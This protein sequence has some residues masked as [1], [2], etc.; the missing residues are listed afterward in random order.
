M[1]SAFDSSYTRLP[2]DHARVFRRLGLHPGPEF[3]I[4]AAATVTGLEPAAVCQFLEA[5]T[6]LHLVEPAGPKRYRIPD[7][8]HAFAAHRAQLDEFSGDYDQAKSRILAWYAR[9]AQ[10]ADRIAFPL[11]P[12]MPTMV[13]PVGVELSFA[14]RLEAL[15]WLRAEH[16][17]L[18]NSVHRAANAGF[19]EVVLALATSARFLSHREHSLST[20]HVEVTSVGEAIARDS[21]D[22]IVQALLLLM[23]GNTLWY[24]D[25]MDASEADFTRALGVGQDLADTYLLFASLA[26]LGRVRMQQDRL[27]E[28][29]EYYQKALCQTQNLSDSRLEAVVHFNLGEIRRRLGDFTQALEHAERELELRRRAGDQPGEAGALCNAA[30]AWQGLGNHAT[31]IDIG[32]RAVERY[33]ALG[34]ISCDMAMAILALARFREQVAD[35][36]GAAVSLREALAV[37][38]QLEDPKVEE[39]R[40]RLAALYDRVAVEG[41]ATS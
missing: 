24:L 3:G 34:D 18:V 27:H 10:R 8:L 28:A 11:L 32:T 25:R 38:I 21:G 33:R 26:S 2:A 6:E 41:L 23:R 13:D 19:P 16:T 5:L 35:L 31:A 29:Q 17:N 30:L 40:E 7:P 14:D 22:R 12:G 4:P 1:E 37:L 20:L 39:T 15:T 9:T 36:P